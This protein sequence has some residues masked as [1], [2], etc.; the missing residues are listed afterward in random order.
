MVVFKRPQHWHID[1][2]RVCYFFVIIMNSD[3]SMSSAGYEEG[4]WWNRWIGKRKWASV[5]S[6][7][8]FLFL[9][10]L[11]ISLVY[12]ITTVFGIF[13]SDWRWSFL[14]YTIISGVT[15]VVALAGL[16][17]TAWWYYRMEGMH[18]YH[19][20][21]SAA[22][23]TYYTLVALGHTGV[24]FLYVSLMQRAGLSEDDNNDGSQF[25]PIAA[26]VTFVTSFI[27]VGA[28]AYLGSALT[29]AMLHEK[30]HGE[31]EEYE[32]NQRLAQQYA[33]LQAVPVG[34]GRKN[35]KNKKTKNGK[36]M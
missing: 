16:G 5:G 20:R 14:T 13:H 6:F 1:D 19:A 9:L 23:Y 12:W 34:N 3:D 26:A 33:Q 30:H 27:L 24:L 25:Q 4:S 29:M 11:G 32:M 22:Y 28:A 35:K 2:S 21:I 7:N 8:M 36:Y 18:H 15:I 17:V 10:T 31:T